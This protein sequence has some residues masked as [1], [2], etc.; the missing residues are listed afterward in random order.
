MGNPEG[1]TDTINRPPRSARRMHSPFPCAPLLPRRSGLCYLTTFRRSFR[2]W[3]DWATIVQGL[4]PFGLHRLPVFCR[5]F[6]ACG[7]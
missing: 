3:V 7:D 4:R 2:A 5:P 6:R 1:V